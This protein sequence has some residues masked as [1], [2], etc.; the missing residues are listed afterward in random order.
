[1]V[2][3]QHDLKRQILS[4]V[5][6]RH[7]VAN[8][9]TQQHCAEMRAVQP[10]NRETKRHYHNVALQTNEQIYCTPTNTQ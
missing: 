9:H 3:K 2:N 8:T 6:Y 7:F 10:I 5:C 1:M 4:Q